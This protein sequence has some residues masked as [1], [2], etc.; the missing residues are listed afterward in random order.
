MTFERCLWANQKGFL[1]RLDSAVLTLHMW[2][3]K[4]V[5]VEHYLHI[6]LNPTVPSGAQQWSCDLEKE[7][8]KHTPRHSHIHAQMWCKQ[9]KQREVKVSCLI[10]FFLFFVFAVY[11]LCLKAWPCY[12][13]VKLA[14]VTPSVKNKLTFLISL[15]YKIL[16]CSPPRRQ[17]AAV[18]SQLT[19]NSL[20]RVIEVQRIERQR[21]FTQLINTFSPTKLNQ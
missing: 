12:Q 17:V 18:S 21:Q 7:T 8:E 1:D 4:Q 3:L 20:K 16:F 14:L 11:W 2:S 19:I 10:V 13:Q 15:L 6:G 9:D 5:Y